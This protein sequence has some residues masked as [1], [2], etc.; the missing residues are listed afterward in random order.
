MRDENLIEV[1]MANAL[2]HHILLLILDRPKIVINL[3]LWKAH[4]VPANT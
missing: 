4:K 3:H 1:A 2:H